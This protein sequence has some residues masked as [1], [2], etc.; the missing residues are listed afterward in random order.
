MH[1]R[2]PHRVYVVLLTCV[3]VS[4]FIFCQSLGS[5][6]PRCSDRPR[7][8]RR[9]GRTADALS[10]HCRCVGKCMH[11]CIYTCAPWAWECLT[12]YSFIRC[13][14][15][16]DLRTYAGVVKNRVNRSI[17]RLGS[18]ERLSE[19]RAEIRYVYILSSLLE[20]TNSCS[21]KNIACT[22]DDKC[23]CSLDLSI[24]LCW[25]INRGEAPNKRVTRESVVFVYSVIHSVVELWLGWVSFRSLLM[26]YNI[27]LRV[28]DKYH[29]TVFKIIEMLCSV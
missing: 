20:G 9:R 11:V 28:A 3:N 21:E 18:P 5:A 25:L 23:I 22:W 10:G 16:M 1:L 26:L 17:S 27:V 14:I 7:D 8:T 6:E 13:T 12:V 24:H 2:N 29:T 15:R 4:I 19:M